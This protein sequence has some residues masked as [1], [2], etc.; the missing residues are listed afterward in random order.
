MYGYVIHVLGSTKVP[1]ISVN[2][3]MGRQVFRIG[4]LVDKMH[5]ESFRQSLRMLF[6][7]IIIWQLWLQKVK[8]SITL[9]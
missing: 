1:L 9:S 4:V 6:L 2:D 5:N 3:P 8:I 7:R